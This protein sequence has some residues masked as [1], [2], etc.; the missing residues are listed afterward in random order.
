M[1]TG[2][3]GH[4]AA[5]GVIKYTLTTPDLIV[6]SPE[7]GVGSGHHALAAPPDFATAAPILAAATVSFPDLV[8]GSR[9]LDGGLDALRTEADEVWL[10]YAQPE[11]YADAV[12]YKLGTAPAAFGSP[13]AA[14]GGR[15]ITMGAITAGTVTAVGIAHRW[16][17]IDTV[18]SRVLAIG[19]LSGD[20]ATELGRPWLLDPIVIVKES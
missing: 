12:T 19:D 6:P 7:I 1:F 18:N 9:V 4:R 14:T 11:S 20:V 3:G 17:A 13:A 2:F 15:K 10:L 5:F 16:A 8:L